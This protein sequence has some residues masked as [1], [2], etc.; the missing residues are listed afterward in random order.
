MQKTKISDRISQR[1]Y[2]LARLSK[3][4]LQVY[5]EQTCLPQYLPIIAQLEQKHDQLASYHLRYSVCSGKGK[6]AR[7]LDKAS[8]I[9]RQIA[10][11]TDRASLSTQPAASQILAKPDGSYQ[12]LSYYSIA[13]MQLH[14]VPIGPRYLG[15]QARYPLYPAEYQPVKAGKA[16]QA[17][18]LRPA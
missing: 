13:S 1:K 6:I 4:C 2:F 14:Q 5:A 15:T 12:P 10:H 17:S 16:S 11:N 7:Q 3:R 9:A 8:M 18:Q